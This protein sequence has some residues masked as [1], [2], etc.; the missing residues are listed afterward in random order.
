VVLVEDGVISLPLQGLIFLSEFNFLLL[1]WVC[2][3]LDELDVGF[4]FGVGLDHKN[5]FN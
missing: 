3:V 5:W 4:V 1:I 2:G